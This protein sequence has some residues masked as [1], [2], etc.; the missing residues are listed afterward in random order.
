[1]AFA[2]D[3][4]FNRDF[5]LIVGDKEIS[6][7]LQDGA[8]RSN[9]Q[10]DESIQLL[11]VDF[12]VERTLDRDPNTA[13]I[14][15]YNLS[16][17]SRSAIQRKE[18]LGD[19]STASD[20]QLSA[21]YINN[22]LRL[23]KGGVQQVTHRRDGPDRVTYIEAEDSKAILTGSRVSQ[24][25]QGP[26]SLRQVL[27]NIIQCSGLDKGNVETALN[28]ELRPGAGDYNFSTG[29]SFSGKCS[30]ALEELFSMLGLRWS[31]QSGQILALTDRLTSQAKEIT[32]K[33][34][35][36]MVGSPEV[37]DEGYV[38]VRTLLEGKIEPGA[39]LIIE[40]EEINGRFRADKVVHSGSTWG[41]DWYTT[42]E[43][44][45]L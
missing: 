20:V 17:D 33:E 43:A 4:Q 9:T 1:M 38:S 7:R 6:A 21:G 31:V 28:S 12:S 26:I 13:D 27:D 3:A 19:V 44:R 8:D 35:N 39:S 45:P 37:G 36:G 14:A 10:N 24:T 23:F 29:Y 41:N 32:I 2:G 16:D 25:Y 11:R 18:Y 5:E 30:D 22:L 34:A 40:S 15:I 42:V